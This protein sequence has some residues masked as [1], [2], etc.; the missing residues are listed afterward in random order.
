MFVL[1]SKEFNSRT[2]LVCSS[3]SEWAAYSC[4]L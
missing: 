3:D 1:Q 4:F 2:V